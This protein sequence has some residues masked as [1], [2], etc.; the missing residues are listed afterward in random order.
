MHDSGMVQDLALNLLHVS[1]NDQIE[2]K[3]RPPWSEA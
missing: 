3:N 1:F 2:D